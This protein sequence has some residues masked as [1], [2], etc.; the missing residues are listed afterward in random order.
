MLPLAV[1]FPG[2]ESIALCPSAWAHCLPWI[3]PQLSSST[4]KP[5]YCFE[6]SGHLTPVFREEDFEKGRWR[7]K[8]LEGFGE[9]AILCGILFKDVL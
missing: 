9:K 8:V 1:L 3:C 7:G 5:N 6:L 4:S 2:T